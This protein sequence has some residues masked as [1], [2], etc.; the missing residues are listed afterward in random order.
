MLH[1]WVE[2]DF[3]LLA[4]DLLHIDF[5]LRSEVE[6][7]LKILEWLWYGTLLQQDSL[8]CSFAWNSVLPPGLDALM[9]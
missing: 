2:L 6:L 9:N 1:E 5:Q 7:C 4:A 8:H 3:L